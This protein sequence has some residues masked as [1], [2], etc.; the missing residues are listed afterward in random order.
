MGPTE[1]RPKRGSSP[2]L[3]AAEAV[4]AGI[5]GTATVGFATYGLTTG[6]PS[7]VG[8]L[9]TV[10]VLGALLGALRRSP[11]PGPVAVGLALLVVGHLAG[12]LVPVGHDVLYNA[13]LG[14]SGARYDHLVHGSAI[15]LGTIVL[16]S[17]V[18][19]P[20][21]PAPGPSLVAVCVLAALG[22]GALNEM[23]EFLTTLAHQGSHVGGYVNTGWDLVSNTVGGMGAGLFLRRARAMP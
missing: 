10:A 6:A 3:S 1:T 7:T 21:A 17:T 18:L 4:A 15:F 20:A 19:E 12:G 13:A 2:A 9:L 16:W 23:V 14:W 11:L 5:A 22:L 8:Y